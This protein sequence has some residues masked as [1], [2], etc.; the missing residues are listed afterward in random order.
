TGNTFTYTLVS[1]TGSTDNGSFTITGNQLKTGA[2]FNAATKSS[3]SIRIRT[4]DQNNL[5]FEQTLTIT[6]TGGNAAPT[7]I[8][9]GDDTVDENVA[10][11]TTVGGFSTTDANSGDTHTYTL[12]AGTGDTDNGAF[13]IVGNTLKTNAS[14]NFETKSSY[15][16]RVRSTDGGNLNFEK[17]F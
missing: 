10:T 12:V 7:N 6:V 14:V 5:F 4:T 9:L 15:S 1:G 8:T 17:T 11:G 16:I 2:V 13:T 3:Y